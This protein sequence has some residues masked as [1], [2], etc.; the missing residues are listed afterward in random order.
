MMLVGGRRHGSHSGRGV[1]GDQRS[2]GQRIV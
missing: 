2:S 1:R